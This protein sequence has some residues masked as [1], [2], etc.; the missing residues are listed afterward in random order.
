TTTVATVTHTYTVAASVSAAVTITD[1]NGVKS[2]SP[3]TALTVAARLTGATA[4]VASP[5]S[6]EVGVLVTFTTSSTGGVSPLSY[7]WGF[8]DG[9][10]ATTTVATVT[11]TYTVA[12]S[13]SAAVTITDVNGVKSASP[14]TALTVAAR[15]TGATAPVASPSSPE[16]GVL[17]TLSTSCTG[18]VSR[19]SD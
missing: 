19:F 18:G 14:V 3:V 16:G 8:G 15:L 9:T 13:V 11:H 5:A 4:P 17:V 10:N 6:P 12:A 2:A 1:V 7:N